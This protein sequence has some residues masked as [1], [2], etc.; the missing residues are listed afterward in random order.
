M[1][2]SLITVSRRRINSYVDDN[3]VEEENKRLFVNNYVEEEN[4][5]LCCR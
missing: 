4:K 5:Q 1:V 2:I 3:R